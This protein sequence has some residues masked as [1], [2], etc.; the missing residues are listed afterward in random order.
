MSSFPVLCVS[1]CRERSPDSRRSNCS[2]MT[3]RT[4]AERLPGENEI[5]GEQGGGGASVVT[6]ATNCVPIVPYKTVWDFERMERLGGPEMITRAWK[7]GWCGL[8]L[9]SWNATKALAHV[10]KA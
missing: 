10:T 2:S 1:F 9:K 5:S 6:A 4:D 7:C 3:S 8:T